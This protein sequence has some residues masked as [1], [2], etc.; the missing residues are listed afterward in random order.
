LFAQ[1]FG[2]FMTR[3]RRRDFTPQ[4]TQ[5]VQVETAEERKRKQVVSAM[6]QA[7]TLATEIAYVYVPAD[8]SVPLQER[9]FRPPHD[10]LGDALLE[11]LKPSFAKRT[12]Q[13]VDVELLKQ[14]GLSTTLAG[15]A[16][17]P[18]VSDNT[19][20]QVASEANVETFSLVHPTPTNNF[21][22]INIYLDEGTV[23]R[24][25]LRVCLHC[26]RIGDVSCVPYPL[27]IVALQLSLVAQLY[28]TYSG[29][30]EAVAAQ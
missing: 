30:A 24:V 10:T 28:F 4:Y 23:E 13:S 9:T 16:D 5:G 12:D 14:E 11:H 2:A 8:T 25:R 29:H 3:R 22:G 18:A 15:S 6:Q 7:D 17:V 20:Q 19:L 27:V 1:L 26:C 21:T